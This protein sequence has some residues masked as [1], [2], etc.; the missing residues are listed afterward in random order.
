MAISNFLSQ[1]ETLLAPGVNRMCMRGQADAWPLLPK[2][3]RAEFAGADGALIRLA[4]S[5]LHQWHA[6]SAPYLAAAGVSPKSQWESIALA[7]H[8]GLATRLLDWTSNPL[9]ALFFAVHGEEGKDGQVIVWEFDQEILNNVSKGPEAVSELVL[10]RPPPCFPRLKFQQ[11]LLSYHPTPQVAIPEG[12]LR[13][14]P[15]PAGA[16]RQLQCELG[17]MGVDHESVF[18]TLDHLAEKINWLSRSVTGGT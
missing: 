11:G 4:D 14:L 7:Q 12:A 10:F 6:E 17:R 3:Y 8:Y 9:I 16:K 15:V 2:A 5:R 1:L 18:G 13:R